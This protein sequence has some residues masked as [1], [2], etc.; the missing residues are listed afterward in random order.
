MPVLADLTI[1]RTPA[2]GRDAWRTATASSTCSIARPA[3]SSVGKPFVQHDVG[4]GRS[5][6]T[7][8][9]VELPE[10]EPT[11]AGTIDVP[12]LY[13]GTNFMSPSFDAT[14]GLFFVTARETCMRFMQAPAGGERRARRSHDGRHGRAGARAEALGALRAIDPATGERKWEI[15]YADAAVGGRPR[16]GRR[17]GVQRRPRGQFLR[18][19]RDDRQEAV[20]YQTGAADL[21]AAH[22]LQIDGRQYV[23]MPSGSTLTAFALPARH[24]ERAATRDRPATRDGW[25]MGSES[26]W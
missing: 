16:D 18:R 14:R 25:M 24:D 19:R 1:R 23:V 3:S 13:G 8:G 5:V 12:G 22:E 20:T 9:R 15:A 7:A 21:R 11:P 26:E 17:R 6:R 2:Q 4:D 10:P